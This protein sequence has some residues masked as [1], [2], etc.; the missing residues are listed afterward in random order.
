MTIL[1][2]TM[3]P[4]R[5]RPVVFDLYSSIHKG[6]RSE[7]FALVTSAGRLDPNDEFGIVAFADHVGSMA[8]LLKHH[9]STE[10]RHIGPVLAEVAPWLA[11]RIEADHEAFEHRFPSLAV[12]AE[13][14]RSAASHATALHEVYIELA[15]FTSSYLTHQD[16]EER[17]VNP[18]LEDAVG[19]DGM[20]AI[21][22]EIIA[23]MNPRELI[24][25]LAV[26]L[27]AMNVDE[28]SGLLG[29]MHATAPAEAFDAVWSL[30]GS[31]LTAAD[32]QA[33]AVR[34]GLG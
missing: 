31:V 24:S 14:I 2:T 9:A 28:R 18:A 3:T 27:P 29:G 15:A 22:H 4:V 8:H 19:P 17:E 25:T 23:N 20:A 26:M 10:D 21:H 13:D 11:D 12:L 7:M 34:I 1:D 16:L 32:H 33:G 6:I 5:F 30:A